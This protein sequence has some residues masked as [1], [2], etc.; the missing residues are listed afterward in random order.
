MI[1][2]VIHDTHSDTHTDSS[3]SVRLSDSDTLFT[4]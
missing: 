1:V 2:I 3:Q 4:C